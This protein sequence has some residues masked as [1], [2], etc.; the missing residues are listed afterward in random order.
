MTGMYSVVRPTPCEM[1]SSHGSHMASPGRQGSTVVNR[2]ILAR[3]HVIAALGA[4]KLAQLSAE[5]VDQWL[6]VIAKTLS[7]DTLHR[8]L[9]ILRQSIR[10]AQARDLVKRNVALLCDVPRGTA[11]RPSKSLTLAQAAGFS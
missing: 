1:L 2:T 11:G 8:L 9:S 5:E 6:A 7:T 10:R 4:R 3:T